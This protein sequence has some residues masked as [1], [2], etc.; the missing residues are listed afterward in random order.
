M[1]VHFTVKGKVS[2]KDHKYAVTFITLQANPRRLHSHPT[3]HVSLFVQWEA[4][5]ENLP[6]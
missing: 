3:P 1:C 4:Q 6:P 2:G 5:D